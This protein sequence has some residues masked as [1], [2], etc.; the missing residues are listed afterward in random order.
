MNTTTNTTTEN[1]QELIQ[2]LANA[3]TT[4][5]HCGGRHKSAVNYALADK[6]RETLVALGVTIPSDA[7]LASIGKFN[8]I[9][10]F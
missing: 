3:T 6:Y 8:G 1:Q 5:A 4:G 7:E 9:G 10:S 2:K